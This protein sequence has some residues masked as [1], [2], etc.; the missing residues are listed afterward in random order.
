MMALGPSSDV[1]AFL[2]LG[3]L[4]GVEMQ[5]WWR[6]I[7]GLNITVLEMLVTGALEGLGKQTAQGLL[8]LLVKKPR[9]LQAEEK[10]RECTIAHEKHFK[11]NIM[12]KKMANE[13]R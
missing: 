4:V 5:I 6:Q 9:D 3:S 2:G 11:E 7:T 13:S 12:K 8:K 1:L 10:R